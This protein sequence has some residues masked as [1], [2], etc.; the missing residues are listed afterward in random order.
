MTEMCKKLAEVKKVCQEFYDQPW[1]VHIS[2]GYNSS[3]KVVSLDVLV[4]VDKALNML[5]NG[6]KF[7][8]YNRESSLYPYSLKAEIDG[9]NVLCFMTSEE[10]KMYD[11]HC[12][13]IKEVK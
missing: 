1:A 8:L 9:V 6:V 7:K 2:A 5:D 11:Q 13:T 10:K 12:A 3:T 4:T